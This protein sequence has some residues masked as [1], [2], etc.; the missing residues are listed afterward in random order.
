MRSAQAHKNKDARSLRA[1][2]QQLSIVVAILLIFIPHLNS[3]PLSASAKD[4]QPVLELPEA[5]LDD[6]ASYEN[7]RTRFFRDSAGN[8]LQ[9]YLRQKTGRIV[10][11]WADAVNESI[12]FTSRNKDGSPAAVA[13]AGMRAQVSLEGRMRTV[14]HSLIFSS[15]EVEIGHFLLGSMRKERDFQYFQKDLTPYGSELFHE[16]ELLKLIENLEKLPDAER[17]AHLQLLNANS[18]QELRTR[19]D[20]KLSKT[21]TEAGP[22]IR[23]EQTTFDGKNHLSVALEVDPTEEIRLEGN[24]I[25]IRSRGGNRVQ[26]SVK[27]GA[28]SPS[29]NPLSNTEILN[30]A[31]F[32][33]Y[34]SVEKQD[35]TRFRRLQREVRGLE[36]VCYREKLMAGLPNFATYFGRDTM[37]TAFMMEPI[38]TV[39]MMEHAIESVLGKIAPDGEVSHEEALGG[40]AIRENADEYNKQIEK[41]LQNPNAAEAGTFL[42]DAKAILKNLQSIRE[43][44]RMLDDDFQFPILVARYLSRT[45]IPQERKRSFLVAAPQQNIPRLALL[46]RNLLRV[47]KLTEAYVKKP[48]ALNLIAFPKVD[49]K[50]WFSGSWRDSGPGYANGRFAMDINAIWV[51]NAL[52]AIATILQK[53]PELGLSIETLRSF[54]P[55]MDGSR[56][57]QYAAQPESLKTAIG[58]WKGAAKHF[59]VHL[60]STEIQ[61]KLKPKLAWFA[62]DERRY[63]EQV[64]SQSG[65]EQKDFDFLALSLD[66]NGKPI[67]IVNTDPATRLFLE[68]FVQQGTLE[69][70]VNLA[71]IF[72]REYPVGLFVEGL[73]PLVANDAYAST[74]IWEVFKKD[75]YHS[76]RVVWG[77]EVNLFLLGVGNQIAASTDHAQEQK[78]AD[79]HIAALQ[80]AFDK[81]FKAVES[82]GLK[83]NELWT[84]R[85]ENGKLMPLRFGTS[86]DV[87]LW[88]LTDVSVQYLSERLHKSGKPDGSN[89]H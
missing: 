68:N 27:V 46:V 83:H 89:S 13:W 5:G 77:R 35:P 62:P 8:C 12:S 25:I 7:Y 56:L 85:I 16:P 34:Q 78:N 4:V 11:L 10:H 86:S 87:Q 45:D 84:Y 48:E 67:P 82:S 60:S 73:G 32:K 29:L 3:A 49:E 40:Q 88:N 2:L 36:L 15:G 14:R 28:D 38:W 26:V 66:E 30:P 1:S 58:T 61:Q 65:A 31:F 70:A 39:P 21:E 20:P 59:Q 64:L 33:F 47:A 43:N 44:Y 54:V 69:E 23:V 41:Y 50:H 22:G 19:M 80:Q 75:E 9:I 52:E 63:W 71:D 76:P 74:E 42:E 79:R 37:M 55:E 24:K 18:T 57:M 6:P 72:V 81:I 51:P 53:L 17:S